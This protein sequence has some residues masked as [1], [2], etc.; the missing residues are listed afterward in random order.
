[1]SA[2]RVAERRARGA[3]PVGRGAFPGSINSKG[4]SPARHAHVGI[5]GS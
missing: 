1:M 2:G 3:A 5:I 4:R